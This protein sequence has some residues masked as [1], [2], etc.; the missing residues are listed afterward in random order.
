MKRILV[1]LLA[2]CCTLLSACSLLPPEESIRVAPMIPESDSI[3]YETIPVERMD[4]VLTKTVSCAYSSLSTEQLLFEAEGLTFDRYYVQLGDRVTAGQLLAELDMSDIDEQLSALRLDLSLLE[5]QID[6]LEEDRALALE[7]RKI[8]MEGN[9][10]EEL[11]AALKE[12][13]AQFDRRAQSLKDEVYLVKLQIQEWE[14]EIPKRQLWA[15]IDGVVHY[16]YD[17]SKDPTGSKIGPRAIRL[18]DPDKTFFVA[19][20]DLWQYLEMGQTFSLFGNMSFYNLTVIPASELGLEETER[21]EGQTADVYFRPDKTVA[22]MEVGD[23]STIRVVLDSREDVLAVPAK[24]VTTVAGQSVIYYVNEDGM[25]AYKPVE[26]GLVADGM[27]EIL[28][29]LEEGEFIIAE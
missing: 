11:A 27:V 8:L 20:T 3:V 9:S 10:A 5:L 6:A 1:I 2:M 17:Y 13:N 23:A 7:R 4:M 29:G 25:R 18:V 21:V 16:L 28:S 15:G 24:A 14:A 12:V 26:T 19:S 22:G